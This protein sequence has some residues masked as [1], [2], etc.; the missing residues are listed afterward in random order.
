MGTELG[1][2]RLHPNI[3]RNIDSVDISML[4]QRS[5][6]TH[7]SNRDKL[8][9]FDFKTIERTA[10]ADVAEPQQELLKSIGQ[11]CYN[12]AIEYLEKTTAY[13]SGE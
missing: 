13:Q 1:K 5:V 4:D 8:F 2:M 10:T 6:P 3:D 7:Q 9:E 12:S 11:D